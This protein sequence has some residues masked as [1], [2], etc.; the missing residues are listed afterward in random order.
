MRTGHGKNVRGLIN[1]R[2]CQRSAAETGDVGAFLC[3]HLD[4]VETGGLSRNGMHTSGSDFDVFSVS[5]HS[6]E[7][8]FCDWAATNV[9]CADEE[10]LF[11]SWERAA[12]A[13]SQRK[14]EPCQVNFSRSK[15]RPFWRFLSAISASLTIRRD[16]GH[17]PIAHN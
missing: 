17:S 12:N 14:S 15:E 8:P 13:V 3:A 16:R 11:H 4:G 1:R 9:S 6:S 7:K 2:C 10:D 5:N